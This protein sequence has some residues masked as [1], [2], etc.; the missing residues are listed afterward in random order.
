MKKGQ[1]MPI[2]LKQKMSE[3]HKTPKFIEISRKNISSA[4]N[5]FGKDNP[6]YGKKHKPESI[7][8]MR[9]KKIGIKYSDEVNKKKGRK[10]ELHHNFGKDIFK[11]ELNPNWKGGKCDKLKLLRSS[12]EYKL[13]R[14]AVFKRD[15]Y[16]CIWC[17]EKGNGKNL[18]ADHIKPFAYFPELRFAIDNGRTLCHSCHTKTDTY[19]S[20]ALKYKKLT[21]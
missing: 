13:W 9:Q 16:T 18:E 12:K 19:L 7:E 21:I 6:F 11:G 17:G 1:K 3:L 20:K 4:I 15:N 8:K 10:G 5:L 2:K 14:E